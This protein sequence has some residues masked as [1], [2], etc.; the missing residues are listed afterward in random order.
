MNNL[1]I[2]IKE[3]REK[4]NI[5]KRKLSELS[6][7]SHTEIQRLENGHRK[8]P[9]PPLLRSIANALNVRYEDIME[10][11]GYLDTMPGTP[12]IVAK[13]PYAEDLTDEEVEKVRTF[14]EFLR[15]KRK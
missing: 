11:A 15:A 10:A 5:S 6:N 3:H 14:I 4:L 2:F 9:S 13:M 8:N 12:L 1:A 7:V